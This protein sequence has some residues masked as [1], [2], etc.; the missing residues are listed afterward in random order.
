[1][2]FRYIGIG[3]GIGIK[4]ARYIGIGIVIISGIGI[5]L[6]SNLLHF[7]VLVLILVSKNQVSKLNNSLLLRKRRKIQK[8]VFGAAHAQCIVYR[9]L[10]CYC[11]NF[12]LYY[13]PPC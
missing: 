4:I 3:I 8:L 9:S 10:L 11:C 5:V 6:V 7:W 2:L 1:M 13:R 12:L